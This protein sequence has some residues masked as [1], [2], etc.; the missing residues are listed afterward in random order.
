MHRLLIVHVE[1]RFEVKV[2]DYDGWH[3]DYTHGWV[4]GIY[5][6]TTGFTPDPVTYYRV[7]TTN[8]IFIKACNIIQSSRN[9]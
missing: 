7:I 4:I 9:F 8:G 5:M 2:F 6:S 3:I 1:A